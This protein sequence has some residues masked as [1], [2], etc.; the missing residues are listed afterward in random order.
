MKKLF[1]FLFIVGVMAGCSSSSSSASSSSDGPV[2]ELT[3]EIDPDKTSY[4]EG[5][6]FVITANYYW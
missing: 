2:S 1:L 3:Y 5:E 4:T 6:Q